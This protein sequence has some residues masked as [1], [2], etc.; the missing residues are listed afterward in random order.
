MKTTWEVFEGV[1]IPL[2]PVTL[3]LKKPSN[4]FIAGLS[5]EANK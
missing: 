5:R 4:E 3:K 2:G 1:D